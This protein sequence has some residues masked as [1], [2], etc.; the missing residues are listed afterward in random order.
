MKEKK[1]IF[2]L[3]GHP[4]ADGTL[5]SVLADEYGRGATEAGHEVR[6]INVG[7]LQFDPILHKG[8]KEIQALEPDLI[9]VQEAFKWA[10]H[11]VIL[12]P[13]WWC[14]MPAL[15]K[16]MFDRM[17]LPGFGF[18]F[19]KDGSGGWD[20]L[21]TGRTARVVVSLNHPPF[22]AR[23]MFGDYTN[24]IRKGILEFAGIWPV[25]LTKIGPV[26]NVKDETRE[27]WKKELH[28]LGKVAG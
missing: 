16:G 24:E 8:Y 20:K 11:I 17:F 7:D 13:N 21:L 23:L 26:Q 5:S 22:K 6:R 10:D 27:Q 19:K 9:K 18:S 2:I 1:K 3:L 15:L 25:K 12:Y 28:D 14:S 4:D